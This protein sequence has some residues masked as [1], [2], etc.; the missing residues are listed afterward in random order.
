MCQFH[1]I[2]GKIRIYTRGK[3]IEARIFVRSKDIDKIRHLDG[4]EVEIFVLEPCGEQ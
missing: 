1:R 3:Y 4:K 2:Y